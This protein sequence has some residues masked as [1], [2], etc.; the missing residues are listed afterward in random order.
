MIVR[1]LTRARQVQ[2]FFEVIQASQSDGVPIEIIEPVHCYASLSKLTLISVELVG[3][4]RYAHQSMGIIHLS[5]FF[6][7]AIS[8]GSVFSYAPE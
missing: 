3:W 1:G 5:S 8:F 4:S 2:V 6:T 7:K